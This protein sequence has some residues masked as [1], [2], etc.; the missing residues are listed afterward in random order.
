M[1]NLLRFV[2]LMKKR[3]QLPTEPIKETEGNILSFM[4]PVKNVEG[5]I[6]SFETSS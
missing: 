6:L 1:L 3:I 5:E 2:V 4:T